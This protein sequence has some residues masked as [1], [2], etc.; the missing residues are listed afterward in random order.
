MRDLKGV[1][2]ILI[3]MFTGLLNG[4]SAA[5]FSGLL[6]GVNL[7]Y[8]GFSSLE[9]GNYLAP[10]VTDIILSASFGREASLPRYNSI[11]YIAAGKKLN[12]H[13]FYL[14][15][16][17]GVIK[18]FE[19][20]NANY[21]TGKD[22]VESELKSKI[23]YK[24]LAGAAYSY[25]FSSGLS[26]GLSL[27]YFGQTFSNDVVGVVFTTD[28][29]YLFSKSEQEEMSLLKGELGISY[30][31]NEHLRL[32]LLSNNLLVL[33][34]GVISDVNKNYILKTPFSITA[35]VSYSPVNGLVLN[36]AL[37]NTGEYAVATDYG[38]R[39]AGG[40]FTVNAGYFG[41]SAKYGV[42]LL[43]ASLGY[44]YESWGVSI[45]GFKYLK[46]GE[47]Y[48]LTD[49]KETGI[50][51]IYHNNYSFDKITASVFYKIN[52]TASRY[53][54]VTEIKLNK[55]IYTGLGETYLTKPFAEAKVL[56]F[57]DEMITLRSFSQIEGINDEPIYSDLV[58]IAPGDTATVSFY[59]I[60]ERKIA[61]S[62]SLLSKAEFNFYTIDES[63]DDTKQVPILLY[64]S[65]A[66]DGSVYNL[67]S[68]VF[69]DMDF[70]LNFTRR[71]L[72]IYKTN[73]DSI[74]ADLSGFFKA[75]LIFNEVVKNLQYV[76]D[77][78]AITD[79][80]QYPGETIKL[81]GG[82]CDDLSVLFSSLFE[83]I[84]IETAF[85]DYKSENGVSHVNLLFNTGLTPEFTGL[86]TENDKKYYIRKDTKGTEFVWIPLETTV[87][88]GFDEA[89]AKGAEKFYEEAIMNYGLLKNQVEIIEVY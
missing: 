52:R 35:S 38:F 68:F 58:Q 88:S 71:I 74:S 55:N 51:D 47:K 80:V 23:T 43:S 87:L 30:L 61:G 25:S 49:F 76:A 33:K 32:G 56:N 85:V 1:I 73:L 77:P 34:N 48:S 60:V 20:A 72:S 28:T 29:L 53:V 2:A 14:R 27:R 22:S 7:Q 8:P 17:P 13:Y 4:Q 57:S 42:N 6:T 24:E 37:S 36:T 69:A 54:K 10:G 75:K 65:N 78:N 41:K 63:P 59:T 15:Y 46:A 67:R 16:S 62:S 45:S 82:D 18:D 84:G 11:N 31:W 12:R 86:I 21:L 50:T 66:W 19:F 83:S 89:W 5:G 26:A 9:G 40:L 64:G 81:K 3:V 39:F 79:R 44:I 70:S